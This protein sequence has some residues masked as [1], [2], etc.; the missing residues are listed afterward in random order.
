[1]RRVIAWFIVLIITITASFILLGNNSNKLAFVNTEDKIEN[2][3]TKSMSETDNEKKKIEELLTK[4]S[5]ELEDRGYAE[6]G[7]SFSF[8]ERILTVQGQNQEF[9]ENSKLEIE[10][11]IFNRS[12]EIKLEDFEVNY[13]SADRY[14]TLSEEDEKLQ[15]STLKVSEL[16]SEL[17]KEKGYHYSYSISTH[18]NKD[19]LIVIE[20]TEE[21]LEK[22]DELEKL[23]AN[24]IFSQTNLEFEVELRKKSESE[25]RDQE[26]QPVFDTIRVETEKEF[27]EYRGFGYSFHPKPL[28]III[29]TNIEKPN[30]KVRQIKKYVD[31]IIELKRDELLMEEIPYKII[32]RDIKDKN[33][34]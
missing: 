5:Q 2:A 29:K 12:K 6:I 31:K 23:I 20:G 4:T 26:W 24:A 19:I 14:I 7:L 3:I 15:E 27:T 1:L 11:I 25:I 33:L 13:I 17:F 28:Q 9:L 10:K 21:D 22:K 34:N 8:G 30:K 32:I 18:P 16:I